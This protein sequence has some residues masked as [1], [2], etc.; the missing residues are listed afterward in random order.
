[1]PRGNGREPG[2]GSHGRAPDDI[3]AAQ[4]ANVDYS[5]NDGRVI[6]PERELAAWAAAVAHL[7]ALGL[8][9]AVPEFP[10]AW[11][12]RR[13]IR[14]DWVASPLHYDDAEVLEGWPGDG[15]ADALDWL[16][17][18]AARRGEPR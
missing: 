7:H 11:L 14:P 8:P 16:A 2:R 4:R 18:R 17:R 1:M 13:G 9:A 6:S 3:T 15:Q 12:R 10:F 5:V